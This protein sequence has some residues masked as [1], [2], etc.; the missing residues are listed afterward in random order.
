MNAPV[1]TGKALFSFSELWTELTKSLFLFK[2]QLEASAETDKYWIRD[3]NFPK[4][5][6]MK[7]I[8]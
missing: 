5:F 1:V 3:K 4:S 6:E 7:T 2:W 8:K